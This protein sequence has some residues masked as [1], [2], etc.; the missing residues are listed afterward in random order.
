MKIHNPHLAKD[1]EIS[2]Q[3]EPD[4]EI[5][6]TRDGPMRAISNLGGYSAVFL[7]GG[8]P[9]FVL[10]SSKSTPKVMSLQGA[11]V[12]NLS[13]FH[14]SGCERGFI[15]TDVNGTARV[16]QLPAN[17]SYDIGMALRKMELGQ[18]VHGVT[19]HPPSE[20]YVVGTSVPTDFE[21]PKD[22]DQRRDWQ[23]EEI[24]FKPTVE[25]SFVKLINPVSWSVIDTF[26][27]DPCE[28]IMCIETLDLEVSE[29]THERRQL[30]TVG[31]AL[32]KGED[33]AIKGRVYVF[34][35]I[36]VIPQAG[37]P[38][39]D[40]RFKL[41][42]KEEIPRG[43]V[44]AVSEVGTQGFMIV[45]QGQKCMIRGLKEDGSL[46][47]VAFMDMNCYVT[48][49]KS[50]PG[51]GLCVMG[52]TIKGAWL[53]GYTEEPY[54]MILFG[55]SATNLEVV[56]AD[57]LPDGE[58]LFIV[59]ADAECNLHVMQYDPERKSFPSQPSFRF[60]YEGVC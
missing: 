53:A 42:A 37:K 54:R 38:E 7:S 35:V 21:L 51:T 5:Q 39:T 22:D 33:L 6:Q 10:K 55:K 2:A 47:P 9:S 20:A 52:D 8:S 29:H 40:K 56:A 16:A 57:L 36:S 46:L 31:T 3:E 27:L 14:T 44:T 45:A 13:G 49:L 12:R 4:E 18:A 25:Q 43:A 19:Y 60:D 41:I 48:A 28:M 24:A 59:V 17:T 58:D 15:Y 26:E 11:G 34:D 30:I 50:I 32:S 23:R 1:P